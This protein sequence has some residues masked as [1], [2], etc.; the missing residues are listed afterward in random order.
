MDEKQITTNELYD[1]MKGLIASNEEIKVQIKQSEED[2]KSEINSV[3]ENLS[4]ELEQIKNEN[5][6]LKQENNILKERI[7]KIEKAEKRCKLMVYNLEEKENKTADLQEFLK[8]L[9]F[10]EVSCDFGDLRDFYRIGREENNKVRPVSIEVTNYFLKEEILKKAHKLRDR[11]VYITLDYP[12]EEYL[13]RKL[14]RKH[15]QI[16]RSQG[17]SAEI[18]NYTLYVGGNKFTL[19]DLRRRE[20]VEKG[21]GSEEEGSG[22]KVTDNGQKRKPENS[23]DHCSKRKT[24]RSGRKFSNTE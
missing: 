13:D 10:A 1:L 9:N 5:Q 20:E 19:E 18:K 4:K 15:Q 3:K 16:A 6:K 14:L 22:R 7:Q 17:K 11:K 23:P 2:I 21:E 24:L 12:R 8:L